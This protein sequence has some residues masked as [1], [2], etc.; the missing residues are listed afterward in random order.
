[1][2]CSASCNTGCSQNAVFVGSVVVGDKIVR[3]TLNCIKMSRLWQSNAVVFLRQCV[4]S[5]GTAGEGDAK[6]AGQ[7]CGKRLD[8][9][10]LVERG[11]L[12]VPYVEQAYAVSRAVDAASPQCPSGCAHFQNAQ[13]V[14]WQDVGF[15]ALSIGGIL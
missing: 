3:G 13:T 5:G 7:P 2:A 14:R 4:A 9:M 12:F 8:K 15:E 1:M 10:R 11:V 6:L